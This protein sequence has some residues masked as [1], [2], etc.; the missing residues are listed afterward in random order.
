MSSFQP[1]KVSFLIKRISWFIGDETHDVNNDPS[2]ARETQARAG[3][4]PN[5]PEPA[6]T[7]TETL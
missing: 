6:W 7:A 5:S 4:A 1:L 3:F 2:L